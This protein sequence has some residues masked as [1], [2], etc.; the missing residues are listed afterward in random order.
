MIASFVLVLN[1]IVI[2]VLIAIVFLVVIALVV[3]VVV[4]KCLSA[5]PSNYCC[6]GGGGKV[7]FMSNSTTVDVE[8]MLWYICGC[9]KDKLLT[10]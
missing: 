8:I 9:D 7:I 1:A 3:L 10:K 4:K 5:T 6:V 2:L